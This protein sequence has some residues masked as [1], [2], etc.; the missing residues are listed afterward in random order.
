MVLDFDSKGDV[1]GIEILSFVF[2]A[3]ENSLS[4]LDPYMRVEDQLPRCVYDKGSDS[5][6][7]QLKPGSS[8]DQR[9]VDGHV[10][11]DVRGRV[12]GFRAE[13]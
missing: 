2:F 10:F 11:Q 1:S 7:L 9:A 12:I 13:W 6:Y 4:S 3:G 5:F 8:V